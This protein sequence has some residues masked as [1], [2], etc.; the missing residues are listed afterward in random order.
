MP[1]SNEGASGLPIGQQEEKTDIHTPSLSKDTRA[2]RETEHS[3]GPAWKTPKE[4][5][6]MTILELDEIANEI[7]KEL[8][9][10]SSVKQEID[11]AAGADFRRAKKN[12][13][14]ANANDDI[15]YH[16]NRAGSLARNAMGK[17]HI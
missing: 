7:L 6:R 17:P 13:K 9:K 11:E 1:K 14:A 8:T 5:D 4:E 12:E 2:S 10:Y 16:Q 15:E 3:E